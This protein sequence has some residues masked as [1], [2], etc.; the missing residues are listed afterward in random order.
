MNAPGDWLS[1]A[2]SMIACLWASRLTTV[3]NRS[4]G[5]AAK[6][7]LRLGWMICVPFISVLLFG[8]LYRFV[9]EVDGV[10][11][12]WDS[13][14]KICR[15]GEGRIIRSEGCTPF[16]PYHHPAPEDR[17]PHTLITAWVLTIF[18][19][20]APPSFN[21]YWFVTTPFCPA[22]KYPFAANQCPLMQ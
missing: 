19:P 10:V 3:R 21:V 7:S 4:R 20:G 18:I 9:S 12:L 13:E 11:F 17:Q 14:Q 6:T 1:P 8:S 2:N 22:V 5:S 15:P 16:A